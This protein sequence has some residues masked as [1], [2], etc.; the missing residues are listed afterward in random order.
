M[1]EDYISEDVYTLTHNI[2]SKILINQ[3]IFESN[4]RDQKTHIKYII[5]LKEN[6]ASI[7]ND[8]RACY[9]IG[10]KVGEIPNTSENAYW[11]E[12]NNMYFFLDA[13][14]N[15]TLVENGYETYFN[16]YEYV[17]EIDEQT[18]FIIGPEDQKKIESIKDL[19]TALNIAVL[20]HLDDLFIKDNTINAD[21][22]Y[23]AYGHKTIKKSFWGDM[24]KDLILET[25]KH[26]KSMTYL[27]QN[28]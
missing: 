12:V 5:I 3:E 28:F 14:V 6:L 11:S 8:L 7:Y 15:R 26:F 1:Y 16:S 4:I 25:D 19:N 23:A 2:S 9:E 24:L 10:E 21:E 20:K 27:E 13:L 22:F 17:N 18:L